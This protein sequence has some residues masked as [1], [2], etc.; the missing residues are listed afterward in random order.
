MGVA[1]QTFSDL[2]LIASPLLLSGA[3]YL[4]VFPVEQLQA[5][6]L[7]FLNV[8]KNGLMVA[9][10]FYSAWLLPLGYLVFKSGFLPKVLGIVLMIHCA[11]WLMTFLQ[12][13]LLPDFTAI[14][15]I[16][17]PLGFIAE[18]GLSLWLL[19]KGIADE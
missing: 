5:V 1:I 9:Q 18:F 7:F 14:T 2:F 8:H 15:Y 17:Y 4:N 3:D 19:L 10:L 6:V 11:T 13:F 16:S 12:Y